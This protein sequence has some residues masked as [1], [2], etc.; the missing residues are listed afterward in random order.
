MFSKDSHWATTRFETFWKKSFTQMGYR[1]PITFMPYDIKIGYLKYGGRN[2]Y[3]QFTNLL[4]SSDDLI[5]NPFTTN[6]NT[7]PDLSNVK[8]RT[9]ISLQLD[10]FRYNFFSDINNKIDI[11][12]G[13]GFKIINSLEQLLFLNGDILKPEFKEINLNTTLIKQWNPNFYNYIYHTIGYNEASFYKTIISN[14]E[15]TGSGLG[16]SMG[17]GFDFIIPNNKKNNDLHCGLELNFSKLDFDNARI[18]EPDNLD[19]IESFNMETVGLVFSFGIGYGG[20]KT[21]ADDAYLN[22]LN[23][24]YILASEQFKFYRKNVSKI[25]NKNKLSD[26]ITFCDTRIP[27]QLYSMGLK[28]YYNNNLESASSILKKINTNDNDLIYKIESLLYTIA[29]KILDSFIEVENDYSIN[30]QIEYYKSIKKISSKIKPAVDN[31]LFNIYL[32]KG[33]LLLKNNNY[34]E[35]YQ[36]YIFANSISNKNSHRIQIKI[37]NVLITVLNDVY[38]LLQNKQNILAY[39]KLSFAKDISRK[40][41]NID[42]LISFIKDR[43]SSDQKDTIRDRIYNIIDEKRKLVETEIKKK[44]YLGD[45]YNT[46]INILGTPEDEI[47]KKQIDNS[48]T[49]LMYSLN[50]MTYR[51]FLKNKILIDIERD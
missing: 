41:N 10:L 9:L 19:R 28:E 26:I 47:V 18:K 48:Y 34:E 50:N 6:D 12:I 37:N 29:D 25:Y 8:D 39:E 4:S 51:L 45:N 16:Y 5:S 13:I 38:N 3:K 15:S 46:I 2:Y 40:N 17:F 27:Y 11:Q 14:K 32:Q 31:R 30:Y 49:M 33:D 24:N 22:V 42:F 7:F 43:M 1:E 20:K 36:Y 35:A 44:V 23:Q 21:L